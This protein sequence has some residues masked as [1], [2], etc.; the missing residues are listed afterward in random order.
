MTLSNLTIKELRQ[1][2]KFN[3][4]NDCII[5]K[6]G[7]RKAGM[8]NQIKRKMT[9]DVF[10]RKKANELIEKKAGRKRE[11]RKRK[12]PPRPKRAPR[13]IR[14]QKRKIRNI[15]FEVAGKRKK[16]RIRRQRLENLKKARAAKARKS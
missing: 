3:N 9:A 2:Q 5:F 15:A 1:L 4:R 14:E 10:L 16:K 12:A 11:P 8:I 13:K 7:T 6:K